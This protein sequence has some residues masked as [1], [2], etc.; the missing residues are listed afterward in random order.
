M[1][2]PTP[3]GGLLNRAL[4]QKTVLIELRN[5]GHGNGCKCF[6]MLFL[7]DAGLHPETVGLKTSWFFKSSGKIPSP[8]QTPQAPQSVERDGYLSKHWPT[9]SSSPEKVEALSDKH[10]EEEKKKNGVFVRSLILEAERPL[11]TRLLKLYSKCPQM[12]GWEI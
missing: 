4:A 12:K 3:L 9:V 1:L 2:H 5:L 7:P 11:Y 6:E 8:P 10:R